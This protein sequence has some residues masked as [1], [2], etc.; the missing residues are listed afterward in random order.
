MQK[1]R[2]ERILDEERGKEWK[3]ECGGKSP[4]STTP[5]VHPGKRRRPIGEG[6]ERE[7]PRA[8]VP[9]HGDRHQ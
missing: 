3:A 2:N 1:E 5:A 8:T 6:G 7:R 4:L 9:D